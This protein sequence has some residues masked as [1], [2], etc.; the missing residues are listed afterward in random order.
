MDL[1]DGNV[2]NLILGILVL[3][4]L[5]PLVW[6][7]KARQTTRISAQAS[8]K[9]RV[10][11]RKPKVAKNKDTATFRFSGT[12]QST[13]TNL[14]TEVLLEDAPESLRA[15]FVR[16]GKI[17]NNYDFSVQFYA[18]PRCMQGDFDIIRTELNYTTKPRLV[19]SLEPLGPDRGVFKSIHHVITRDE[20]RSGA[21]FRF[22]IPQ[23]SQAQH[24]GLYLCLDTAE[25][26]SCKNKPVLDLADVGNRYIKG[27]TKRLL[28]GKRISEATDKLYYFHYFLIDGE[29]LIGFDTSIEEEDYADAERYLHDIAQDGGVTSEVIARVQHLNTKI[30]SM[31]A[32]IAKR[33]IMINLPR[34]DQGKCEER[35]IGIPPGL[36]AAIDREREK[37]LKKK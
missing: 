2:Q 34:E 7:E 21:K 5:I 1:K 25:T 10:R 19:L 16:M 26:N 36:Q 3:L 27:R 17:Q 15:R 37:R 30:R 23:L 29:R 12:R 14:H 28:G 6:E 9:A 13:F 22:R 20:F 11:A 8:E 18:E 35:G 31:P 24:V 4:A 32:K 33:E